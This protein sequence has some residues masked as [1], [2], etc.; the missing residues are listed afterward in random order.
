MN[1]PEGGGGLPSRI[2][3]LADLPGVTATIAGAFAEDPLW[4][5]AFPDD[6]RREAWWRFLLQSILR[7]PCTWVAGDFEAVSAWVPPGGSELTDADAS[8][9]AHRL[10]DQFLPY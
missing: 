4:S 2:A 1:S 8:A 6:D 10:N 5:W 3:T 7:Y 9:I